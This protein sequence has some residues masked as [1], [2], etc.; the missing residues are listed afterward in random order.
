MDKEKHIWN[1]QQHAYMFD[2]IAYLL[3][4]IMVLKTGSDQLVRSIG[5]EKGWTGIE[6]VESAGFLITE[7]FN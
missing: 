2:I 7:W 3:M 6:P 5:P 1:H 4:V